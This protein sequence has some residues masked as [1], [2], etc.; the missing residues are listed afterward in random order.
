[1]IA[2]HIVIQQVPA[3]TSAHSLPA[4]LQHI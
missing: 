1:V 4:G 3:C 2:Q